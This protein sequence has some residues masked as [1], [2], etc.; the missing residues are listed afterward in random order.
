MLA[1]VWFNTSALLAAAWLGLLGYWVPAGVAALAAQ[2]LYRNSRHPPG[3]NTHLR[4]DRPG[5]LAGVIYYLL[6]GGVV[7]N[8][9]LDADRPSRWLD[10]TGNAVFVYTTLVFARNMY[11]TRKPSSVHS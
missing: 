7:L 6:V 8:L 4:E 5:K 11:R 10:R 1:D 3:T 2:Y 9:W